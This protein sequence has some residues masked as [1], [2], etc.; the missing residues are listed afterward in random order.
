L[1]AVAGGEA[2]AVLAAILLALVGRGQPWFEPL[3]A[4]LAPFV[5][6]AGA[7]VAWRFHRGRALLG[8]AAT[9][10]GLLAFRLEGF[11]SAVLLGDGPVVAG[12]AIVLTGV[13]VAAARDRGATTLARPMAGVIAALWLLVVPIAVGFADGLTP[14]AEPRWL[15]R[16]LVGALGLP[17]VVVIGAVVA[18]AGLLTWSAWKRD[19]IARAAGW[20]VLGGVAALASWQTPAGALCAGGVAA[21]FAVAAIEETYVLAFHDPLTGLPAR[22]ALEAA[23]ARAASPSVVAMVD[24]DHFKRFNDTWGHQVG[25]QVLALVATQLSRVP[26][27][28]AFRYG[29]EEF[30]LLLS[31][32]SLAEALP[33]LEGARAAVEA[34]GFTLRG[35]DRPRRRPNKGTRGPRPKNDRTVAVTVSIGAAELG[36]GG[37]AREALAAAD[38][39]LYRAKEA[40][41]NRIGK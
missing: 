30:T 11:R 15:P 4:G 24:V 5:L 40:G 35:A 23:L 25:D 3:A 39:A 1:F 28:Q 16:T 27:A 33:L 12:A 29:G 31:G 34:T 18:W 14:P 6:L 10:V 32:V 2:L 37:S 20:G 17:E 8:L 13:A 19:P 7:L 22:R 26:R 41:R 38:Q 36:A 21:G 9:G